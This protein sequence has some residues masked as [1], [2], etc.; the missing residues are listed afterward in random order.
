MQFAQLFSKR[1]RFTMSLIHVYLD[2]KSI[3]LKQN[4]N[5]KKISYGIGIFHKH[6]A[7]TR[8]ACS[9]EI[10]QRGHKN[11]EVALRGAMEHGSAENDLLLLFYSSMRYTRFAF[12]VVMRMTSAGSI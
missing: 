7:H 10:L 3:I 9:P 2:I 12:S 4:G 5:D 1:N 6:S 11:Q 8:K